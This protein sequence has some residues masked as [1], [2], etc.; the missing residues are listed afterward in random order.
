MKKWIISL[1]SALLIAF[2]SSGCG[3]SEGSSGTNSAGTGSNSDLQAG[4]GDNTENVDVSMK[5]EEV[6]STSY[7]DKIDLNPGLGT[8]PQVPS[9]N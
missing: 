4:A 7:K 2:I 9:T 8:P 1:A 6:V 5:A 3:G